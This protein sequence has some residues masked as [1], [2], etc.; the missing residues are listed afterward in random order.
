MTYIANQYTHKQERPTD[1]LF[2]IECPLDNSLHHAQERE[3]SSHDPRF[4]DCFADLGCQ[5]VVCSVGRAAHW[6]L[7]SKEPAQLVRGKGGSEREI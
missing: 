7:S 4:I 3:A 6:R 2:S 1:S 5:G